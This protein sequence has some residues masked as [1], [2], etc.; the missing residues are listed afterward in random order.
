MGPYRMAPKDNIHIIIQRQD[1]E[2]SNDR[3]NQS[4]GRHEAGCC[5]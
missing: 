1:Q 4:D 5:E 2:D 3:N